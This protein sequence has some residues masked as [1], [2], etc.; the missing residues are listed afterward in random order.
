MDD[1]CLIIARGKPH[2]SVDP[3]EHVTMVLD[4]EEGNRVTSVHVY[5]DGTGKFF[6]LK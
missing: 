3:K 6:K 5:E 1:F 2:T 4:D